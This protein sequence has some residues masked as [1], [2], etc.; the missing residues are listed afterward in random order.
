MWFWAAGLAA[1]A[2]LAYAGF[3]QARQ[4]IYRARLPALPEL[5]HFP[6]AVR[7]HLTDADR[8]ARSRPTAADTVGAL[9][10]AYHADLFYDQADASYA[11]AEQL[12]GSEWRWTYYRALARGARG[13]AAGLTAGL[14]RVVAVAPE[15]GPA[16]WQ[17]GEA[18]FKA[19]RPA[20]AR[21]A[22]R[23]ALTLPEPARL[24]AA[25]GAVAP[26]A[27]A[28]LS[29]YASMGLARLALSQGDADGARVL[30]EPVTSNAPGFGA[31]FGLLSSAYAALGRP[32]DARRAGR[33]ADRLPAYEPYI[34]PL[35][36]VLVRE[37]RSSTFLLQQ[38][39][40]ADLTTN[41]AWRESLIRRALEI[42]PDNADALYDLASMLRVLRRY[43]DALG[44]LERHRRLVPDDFQV[45]ADM[46]RC[47]SGLQRYTEAEPLLVRA[48]EGLDDANGRYD[49]GLVR[50]RL[51]RID[52]AITEYR[53][54]LDRNPNHGNALNNLGVAFAR[55]GRMA[56]A[57]R[58][59]ER[60][61]ALEP[62]N[63]D[64]HANLGAILITLGA[65][66]RAAREFR[67]ALEVDSAH[68][69][70]RSGLAELGAAQKPNF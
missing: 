43:G 24:P 59:F 14:R 68:A 20:E 63:A 42:E 27:G 3:I 60:L 64:A 15:F 1:A 45:L 26:A 49:L 31:A 41:A 44:L 51:G 35:I 33:I 30:L 7:A 66:E 17:I 5:A 58:Q 57:A 18:A 70:A 53:L 36:D 46:G 40:A 29:A 10:L 22:W 38:A 65:R 32:E 67:A 12:N 54:A 6:P 11:V 21:D 16:W 19:G 47:L 4:A 69:R 28:P 62:G 2:I 23:R 52:E 37:S 55:R 9:G 61:I 34:D 25:S 50:D 56:D 48:L 13:D 39:A 8:A